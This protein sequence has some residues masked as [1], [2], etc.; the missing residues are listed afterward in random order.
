MAVTQA[1]LRSEM[2]AVATKEGLKGRSQLHG[3]LRR[4]RP[5]FRRLAYY[6]I[7]IFCAIS[8]LRLT[9]QEGTGLFSLNERGYGDSYVFYTVQQYLKTGQI[10]P[11][12]H[13][14]D[15]LPSQYSPLLYLML[16]VP[17]RVGAWENSYVGPRIMVLA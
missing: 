9:I 5:R 3:A 16:S 17:L 8:A 6:V 13:S 1:R 4:L 15:Q 10:Y 11:D 12:L 2:P 14:H 7:L